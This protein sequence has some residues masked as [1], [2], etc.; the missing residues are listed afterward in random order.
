[1]KKRRK[2]QQQQQQQQQQQK[3]KQINSGNAFR[4]LSNYSI[5]FLVIERGDES[6]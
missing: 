1:M 2:V 6:G 5:V 4:T 3:T